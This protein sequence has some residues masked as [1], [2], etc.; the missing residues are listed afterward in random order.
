MGA[1]APSEIDLA[2]WVTDAA[3]DGLKFSECL[4][5]SMAKDVVA[6]RL[7]DPVSVAQAIAERV[8]A[9]HNVA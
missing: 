7:A 9:W 1:T 8:T 5:F 3:V 4:P 2:P 6:R